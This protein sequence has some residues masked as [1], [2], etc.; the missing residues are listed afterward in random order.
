MPD[1]DQGLNN[2]TIIEQNNQELTVR[3]NVKILLQAPMILLEA[4]D[5]PHS[6]NAY[7]TPT[8]LFR[9]MLVQA[10]GNC[11]DKKVYSDSENMKK[12][13]FG[14]VLIQIMAKAGTKLYGEEAVQAL[15]Q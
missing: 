15:T 2:D 11:A 4:M 10:S 3:L 13:V 8:A 6:T 9:M 14:K 12:M 5:N 1:T 7:E